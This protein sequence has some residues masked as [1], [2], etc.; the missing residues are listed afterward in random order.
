MYFE[1]R[2]HTL[3]NEIIDIICIHV[4]NVNIIE[5]IYYNKRERYKCL[6]IY[7]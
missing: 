6:R 4:Y 7:V 3:N 2:I 5:C 1:V